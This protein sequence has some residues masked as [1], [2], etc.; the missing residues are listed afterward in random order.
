MKNVIETL[1]TF[2][3][4][5]EE[6][7]KRIL[8]EVA[9]KEQI[10]NERLRQQAELLGKEQQ[11]KDRLHQQAEIERKAKEEKEKAELAQKQAEVV[12][13]AREEERK[14]WL[15]LEQE[16]LAQKRLA[17]AQENENKAKENTFLIE[18]ESEFW[19]AVKL[20]NTESSIRSYIQEHPNG[21]YIDEALDLHGK[22]R[23]I[24][25]K[26]KI[27]NEIVFWERIIKEDDISLY[28]EYIEKY[29]D[30]K[31]I[32]TAKERY[33]ELVWAESSRKNNKEG[34]EFYVRWFQN[35][36]YIQE[37]KF[38][39]NAF[40]DK[41]YWEKIEGSNYPLDYHI[42]IGKYGTNGV[43]YKVASSK[44]LEL[45][46]GYWEDIKKQNTIDAL[47]EYI[48]IYDDW[49]SSMPKGKYIKEAYEKREQ[50]YEN[51]RTQMKENE[52]IEIEMVRIDPRFEV[53]NDANLM[54]RGD[55]FNY[56]EI[57]FQDDDPDYVVNVKSNI[58]YGNIKIPKR[59]MR[60]APLEIRYY[61][62]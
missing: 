6:K 20:E 39:L 53:R 61:T 35:G 38:R 33:E 41:E 24:E 23:E 25:V 59:F 19:Q 30:G 40:E 2:F 43:G 37:A 17:R 44:L 13:K 3:I 22:L 26:Q 11:E 54:T 18:N 28:K 47:R 51:R 9:R 8:A 1:K 4:S 45:E 12:R 57:E 29:Y 10:E 50:Y 42:Y 16:E 31:F 34:Y 14:K 36:K 55:Y 5:K 60:S 62:K 52:W 21:K 48:S 32:A 15:E 58:E 27:E 49:N 46:L 7:E 56:V